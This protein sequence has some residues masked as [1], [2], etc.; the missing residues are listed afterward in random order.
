MAEEGFHGDG[1]WEA[2]AKTGRTRRRLARTKNAMTS[3][4]A[5]HGGSSLTLF[6]WFAA[7]EQTRNDLRDP[8]QRIKHERE[9][10]VQINLHGCMVRVAGTD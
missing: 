8:D 5:C 6:S 3:L 4:K 1:L 10:T 9:V 7:Q 2:K